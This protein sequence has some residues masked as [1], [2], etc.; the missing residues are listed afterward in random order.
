MRFSAP[1]TGTWFVAVILGAVGILSTLGIV[2]IAVISPYAFWLLAAGFVL[3][4]LATLF[5][6]L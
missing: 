5:K 2:R 6:G 3:L 1:K 4:A